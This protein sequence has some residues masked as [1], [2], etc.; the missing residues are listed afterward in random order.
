MWL[1]QRQILRFFTGF[2]CVTAVHVTLAGCGC[3]LPYAHTQTKYNQTRKEARRQCFSHILRT[4][5]RARSRC[6]LGFFSSQGRLSHF[7]FLSFRAHQSRRSRR[8]AMVTSVFVGGAPLI[9]ARRHDVRSDI[10]H[11]YPFD[12]CSLQS[13]GGCQRSE[14]LRDPNYRPWTLLS[15]PVIVTQKQVSFLVDRMQ[16]ICTIEAIVEHSH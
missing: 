5:V 3:P 15:L 7:R 1:L 14:R 2:G 6:Q 10:S 8:L 13:V 9:C 4:S 12:D 11:Q 16:Q